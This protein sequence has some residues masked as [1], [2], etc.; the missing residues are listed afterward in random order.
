VRVKSFFILIF[1]IQNLFS[2]NDSILKEKYNKTYTKFSVFGVYDAIRFAGLGFSYRTDAL[3]AADLSVGA[4]YSA[5]SKAENYKEYFYNKGVGLTLNPKFYFDNNKQFYVG[6]YFSMSE[7]GFSKQ[8]FYLNEYPSNYSFNNGQIGPIQYW[9]NF[10]QSKTTFSYAVGYS[11]GFSKKIK[12]LYLDFFALA[13][14]EKANSIA[15]WCKGYTNQVSDYSGGIIS[16]TNDVKAYFNAQLGLKIGLGFKPQKLL[17]RTYYKKVFY[18]NLH[19]QDVAIKNAEEQS[20]ISEEDAK[21]Y[22]QYKNKGWQQIKKQYNPKKSDTET[23]KQ[24][25]ELSIQDVRDF[26]N[27][28]LGANP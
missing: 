24:Q 17:S 6:L 3:F 20:V 2:Q 4:I 12:R 25:T 27:N 1:F 19:Q 7:Y 13:G 23:L 28:I 5:Y 21:A 8:H 15:N 9:Y 14:V 26:A 10:E 16:S 11:L 18:K 22:Y